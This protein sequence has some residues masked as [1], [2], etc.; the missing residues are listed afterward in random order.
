MYYLQGSSHFAKKLSTP[1]LSVYGKVSCSAEPSEDEA[2]GRGRGRV[3]SRAAKRMQRGGRVISLR[4]SCGF[5][6]EH[7]PL[8]AAVL[9]CVSSV[10][11]RPGLSPAG[12]S[13]RRNWLNPA[14]WFRH[15]LF[16]TRAHG[17]VQVSAALQRVL[18]GEQCAHCNRR[19]W[20]RT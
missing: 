2:V 16:S 6:C 3:P 14:R 17:K 8:V 19:R 1:L 12:I 4:F 15:A 13:N 11:V 7:C 18:G 9:L 5:V 10:F 20:R